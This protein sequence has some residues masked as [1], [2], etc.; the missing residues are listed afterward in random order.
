MGFGLAQPVVDGVGKHSGERLF[1]LGGARVALEEEALEF[2]QLGSA[3]IGPHRGE[4]LGRLAGQFGQHPHLPALHL[5]DDRQ[6]Q[7]FPGSEVVQQHSMTGADGLGHPAQRSVA[8][9][10]GGELGDQAIEQFP[11]P[12]PVRGARHRRG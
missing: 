5:L 2:A 10:A 7:A 12:L 9:A 3:Q 6:Q 8:D 1:A 4:A 11:A